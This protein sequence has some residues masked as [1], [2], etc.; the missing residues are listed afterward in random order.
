MSGV[1]D[2]N[3]VMSDQAT[4][5]QDV[6]VA[7]SG[8]HVGTPNVSFV[9]VYNGATLTLTNLMPFIADAGLYALLSGDTR[10]TWSS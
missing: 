3:G 7:P 2:T 5:S 6:A 8:D 9:I 1:Q 10:V 4:A